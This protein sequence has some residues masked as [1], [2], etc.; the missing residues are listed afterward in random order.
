[1]VERV[2]RQLGQHVTNHSIIHPDAIAAVHLNLVAAL[3]RTRT[4]AGS[5]STRRPDVREPAHDPPGGTI[6]V[7]G[8]SNLYFP[9]GN[10]WGT[11]RRMNLGLLACSSL[12]SQAC[13]RSES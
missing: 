2:E 1:V 5:T 6:Y 4:W 9:Q 7:D 3:V 12:A 8:S 11:K 10:G 13:W